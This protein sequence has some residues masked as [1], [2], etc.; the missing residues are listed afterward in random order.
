MSKDGKINGEG[1]QLINLMEE[2]GCG[3]LNGCIKGDEEGEYTFTGGKR[4]TVIDYAIG[5][6][7][8]RKRIENIRIGDRVDSDHIR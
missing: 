2:N 8:V 5:D 3:I 7:E 1:R 6:L 4:N